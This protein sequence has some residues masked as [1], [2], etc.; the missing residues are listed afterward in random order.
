MFSVCLSFSTSAKQ[1]D[2]IRISSYLSRTLADRWCTTV[3]FTTS[4]LYSSRFS[5]FRS[6]IFHSRPVHSLMLSS[7]RFLCLPLRL[8][9]CLFLCFV[10][11]FFIL[12]LNHHGITTDL[13][14]SHTSSLAWWLRRRPRERKI[15]GSN[16]ACDGIF[17]GRV[18]PV[19]SKLAL[20]WLPCQAAG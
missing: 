18:I 5:A 17:P 19:T 8:S 1:N 7:H 4:F 10:I 2:A 16:P 3:D 9:A 12:Y 20:Q 13:I 15:L 11:L 6:S 14:K